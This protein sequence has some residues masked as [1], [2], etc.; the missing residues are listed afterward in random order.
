MGNKAAKHK[1]V[2]T[3]RTNVHEA[4]KMSPFE[5]MRGRTARTKCNPDWLL[6][7]SG[8]NICMDTIKNKILEKH[9]QC[10]RLFDE[11]LSSGPA[12]IKADMWVKV[13]KPW[14]VCKGES[15]FSE[16]LLVKKVLS[17]AV[18]LSDGKVW[19]IRRIAIYRGKNELPS[20][21]PSVPSSTF[22]EIDSLTTTQET[23]NSNVQ[24]DCVADPTYD[25]SVDHDIVGEERGGVGAQ[26]NEIVTSGNDNTVQRNEIVTPENNNTGI[27]ATADIVVDTVKKRVT[28]KPKWLDDFIC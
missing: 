20:P 19:N 13:K 17:N 11:K 23:C 4:L 10:K 22:D 16:P 5:I 12:D 8:L 1:A 14:K 7:S 21:T 25:H 27:S 28:S 18:L 2:W 26:R 24:N 6:K 3:Y 9:L 15:Q